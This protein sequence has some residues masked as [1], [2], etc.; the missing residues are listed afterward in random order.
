VNQVEE[1]KFDAR[2]SALASVW[3]PASRPFLMLSSASQMVSELHEKDVSD[4]ARY[5]KHVLPIDLFSAVDRRK[6][7]Y[8]IARWCAAELL[9]CLGAP[10]TEVGS[11][12]NREPLWPV[13]FVGSITHSK[14][15]VA[16]A[17]TDKT[18]VSSIGID[19][20]AIVDKNDAYYIA[21]SCLREEELQMLNI[22][23]G[24]SRL[25]LVTLIFSAKEA[26]FKVLYPMVNTYFDFLD[27]AI[28]SVNVE[29]HTVRMVLKRQ[30][31]NKVQAGF[32]LTGT[33]NFQYG[34]VFTA[35]ELIDQAVGHVLLER[36]RCEYPQ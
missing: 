14:L 12:K 34:Y 6:A 23:C 17:V 20:E 9:S 2:G 8:V 27:A 16:V 7:E 13:G 28:D 33:F 18:Q 29:E 35:F 26:F 1:N 21:A 15:L 3:P 31:S 19:V 22:E 36:S 10:T 4:I 11:G 32:S 24:L 30:L 5:W 25:Q